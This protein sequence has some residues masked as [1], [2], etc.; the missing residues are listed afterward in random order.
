MNSNS[1]L[2]KT[3]VTFNQDSLNYPTKIHLLQILKYGGTSVSFSDQSRL[4][5]SKEGQ[6]CFLIQKAVKITHKFAT[7]L[8]I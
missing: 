4:P 6:L 5:R 7:K 1:T 8:S 3:S 2:A